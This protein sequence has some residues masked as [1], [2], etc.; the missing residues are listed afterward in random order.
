MKFRPRMTA[1]HLTEKRGTLKNKWLISLKIK[2]K[3][4]LQSTAL[5][6]IVYS[7]SS[8]FVN[9]GSLK[10]KMKSVPQAMAVAACFKLHF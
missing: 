2:E 4:Q 6:K 5:T 1:E 3:L 8:Y 9:M 7:D 10:L